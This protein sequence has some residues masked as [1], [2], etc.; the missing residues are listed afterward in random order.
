MLVDVAA[1]DAMVDFGTE[2]FDGKVGHN[3]ITAWENRKSAI[4]YKMT[5]VRLVDY[6]YSRRDEKKPEFF[7]PKNQ[8]VTK[9]DNFAKIPGSLV[10]YWVSDALIDDFEKGA[11]ISKYIQPRQ[12][13]STCDVNRFAKLWYEVEVQKTNV[14]DTKNIS[15]WVRY[16]KGGNFR[17]WYGNR[18][19]VVYWGT[20]GTSLL[21]N[22]A[23][24]RNRE[25]YFRPFLAWTKISSMG[26]GFRKFEEGLL[27]DGAGGSLFVN[28]NKVTDNY[29]LGMRN[30][31]VTTVFF[32]FDFSNTKFQ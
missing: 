22:G 11:L 28:N 10:A 19:Y 25:V 8:Y 2:L 12:G 13:M 14:L 29:L 1:L 26:T 18:E 7:N 4:N 27:F 17:K 21:Q 30:S 23:L 32:E 15:E 6:R 5:A 31:K 24:L 3:P 9:Q 20:D 16:N